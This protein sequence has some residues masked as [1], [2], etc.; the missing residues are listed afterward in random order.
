[1]AIDPLRVQAIC[2]DI[3]GTIVDTD[4]AYVVRL[5]HCLQPFASLMPG[6]SPSAL[7]RRLVMALESP[8]NSL[9]VLADTLGVDEI[10]M[11]FL[12]GLQHMRG[13]RPPEQT[14]LIEGVL[15]ALTALASRYPLAIVTA[16]SHRSAHAFLNRHPLDG[17]F[18]TVVTART[19]R[20]TKPHPAPVL[21]AAQHMG[22]SP[23]A[24]LMVGDTTPDILSGKAAGAQTV[25][26]LCGFGEREELERAGADLILETTS[27]LAN[28]L[29]GSALS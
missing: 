24:C 8:I 26:V 1:M 17:L 22:V 27:A 28:L 6:R 11:C 15:Q 7:A 25:G 16:R 14:R 10:G 18:S 9:V 12:D 3:D 20:R 21:L 19:C 23:Q 2:L 13:A 29:M 5:A 4:D